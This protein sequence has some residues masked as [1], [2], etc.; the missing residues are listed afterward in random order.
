MRLYIGEDSKELSI[1]VDE[2]DTGCGEPF[3]DFS[4]GEVTDMVSVVCADWGCGW[5]NK[6]ERV[7]KTKIERM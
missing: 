1:E 2:A 6:E 3:I 5:G 4:G 7:D